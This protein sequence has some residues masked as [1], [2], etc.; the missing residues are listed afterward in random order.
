MYVCSSKAV[1]VW[2]RIC[3]VQ[4]LRWFYR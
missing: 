2:C 1:V 3:H 4:L